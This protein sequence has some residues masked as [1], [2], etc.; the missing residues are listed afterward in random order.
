VYVQE[1]DGSKTLSVPIRDSYVSKVPIHPTTPSEIASDAP[2]FPPLSAASKIKPNIDA[3]F[4]RQLRAILFRIA[5][6]KWI[7]KETLIVVFHSFFLVL[8]T[9]LS[10]VVARL[11]GRIVGDLVSANGKGFIK[12]LGL[13]FLLAIPST[14]TNSIVCLLFEVFGMNR[15]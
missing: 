13:W 15:E 1:P 4:L 2:H 5:F 7:S 8:R 12:G 6:S 14:Y 11:D 10:I 9:V 3:T